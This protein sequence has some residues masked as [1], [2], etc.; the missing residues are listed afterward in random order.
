MRVRG[1]LPPNML[2][3]YRTKTPRRTNNGDRTA[4]ATPRWHGRRRHTN[5][6][7]K[8]RYKRCANAPN[9]PYLVR[10]ED[11]VCAA[12]ECDGRDGGGDEANETHG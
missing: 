1:S 5:A 4:R 7:N 11:G 12:H 8:R 10:G 9:S 2:N 6:S 3:H